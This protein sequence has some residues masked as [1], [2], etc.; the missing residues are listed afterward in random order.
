MNKGKVG[1]TLGVV[2]AIIAVAVLV[3]TVVE[4]LHRGDSALK[5]TGHSETTV[6][7]FIYQSSVSILKQAPHVGGSDPLVGG[8]EL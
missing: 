1:Q 7:T 8:P 5:E 3:P 2:S 6:S 4:E